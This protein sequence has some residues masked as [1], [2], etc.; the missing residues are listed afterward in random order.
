MALLLRILAALVVGPSLESS[1][2]VDLLPAFG[3][4]TEQDYES[5]SIEGEV[6]ANARTPID[7]PLRDTFS[8]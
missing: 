7:P 5:Y 1:S 2:N 4:T 6:N 3:A 8:Y